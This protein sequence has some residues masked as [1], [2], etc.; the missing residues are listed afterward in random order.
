MMREF[1]RMFFRFTKNSMAPK[2]F[3]RFVVNEGRS[4]IDE[5]LSL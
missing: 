1:V 2:I 5:Q 3:L 4:F